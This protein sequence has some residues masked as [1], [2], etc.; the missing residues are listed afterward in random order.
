MKATL[1][2]IAKLV[3]GE[4][5]GNPGV[6]VTGL[7]GL[8]DATPHSLTFV[9][10]RSYLPL[11]AETRAAAAVV[12]LDVVSDKLPLVRVKDPDL[13]FALIAREYVPGPVRP[14]PGVHP[15]AIVASD[16]IL[17]A[18]VAV[19]AF[20]VVESGA[21]IGR[22]SVLYPGVYVGPGAV[23]G[24]DCL[25]YP[26]VVVRDAV[27]IGDRCILHPGVV[28]G[29]DGFG[30]V[31]DGDAILKVPQIGTVII[32][33]D[34]E[35]GACTTIDRARLDATVV[36]DG[37]KIDNLVQIGHNVRIGRNCLIVAQTG[38]SGSTRLGDG[39]MVGGQV[40][41]S[42]HIELGDGVK[43]AARAGVINSFP[44]GKVISGEP[45]QEHGQT[46]RTLAAARRLPELL[47]Q[48]H[49]LSERI[50]KLEAQANNAGS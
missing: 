31:P 6:V 25:L 29:A 18:D 38:I 30:F 44:A 50:A 2:E 34:V 46:L 22:G 32:G 15:G 45:A 26:H 20:V 49:Q 37:A 3:N 42:G 8:R 7:A 21:R 48:V 9:S 35:I 33:N 23:V 28:V 40:G 10:Q 4:V 17:G 14:K 36:G 11:L 5:V 41:L 13:A 19:S 27:K 16:A 43:V 24:E 1:S 47:K 12:G 39:C